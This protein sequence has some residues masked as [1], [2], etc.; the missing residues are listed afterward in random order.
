MRLFI[1]CK[2]SDLLCAVFQ[3]MGWVKCLLCGEHTVHGCADD[4]N[5]GKTWTCVKCQ[6][7]MIKLRTFL[8]DK[9]RY[10][11]TMGIGI[12]RCYI[13]TVG[14]HDKKCEHQILSVSLINVLPPSH[15][16]PLYTLTNNFNTNLETWQSDILTL[17]PGKS[18]N[19]AKLPST[20][21]FL[22]AI[23]VSLYI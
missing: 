18:W 15:K 3:V 21:K 6:Q 12:F 8:S 7:V 5:D 4:P 16:L 13:H 10:L 23:H 19:F 22:I 2:V 1:D 11:V 20:L 17:L 9:S 14:R